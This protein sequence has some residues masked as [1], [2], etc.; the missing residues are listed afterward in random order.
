[1][2]ETQYAEATS[3]CSGAASLHDVLAR[4]EEALMLL[5]DLAA[6]P[7]LGAHL[8]LLIHRTR[9]EIARQQA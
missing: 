4:L 3:A 2:S 8:D 6:S 9:D 1:M 5:D 7:E